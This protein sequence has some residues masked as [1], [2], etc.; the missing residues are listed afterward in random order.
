MVSF[1]VI[2]YHSIEEIK[3]FISSLHQAVS[4]LDCEIIISSNSLYSKEKQTGLISEFPEAVWTFNERN[5]GFAYGMNEGLKVAKGD[6][7]T[8]VNP[9][10]KIQSSLIPMINYLESNPKVGMIAPKI[11]DEDGIIQ[12][13]FRHFVTPWGFFVRQAG[14][15]KDKGKL[16]EKNYQEPVSVDWVIGAFMMCRR[17]FY[18]KAGGLS[19]DY[20]MY[21]EDMD[22]C[23]RV[24]RLGY[25]VVYF[26]GTVIEYKGTRSARKSWKYAKIHIHS[27]L[28]YWRK[29][30]IFGK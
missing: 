30:G 26:P 22:W 3:G 25:E 6:I 12:D 11:V 20:F 21:C 17:D 15:I 1:I 18:D 4:G 14:R 24:H 5:G 28:T 13:S 29:Y 8:V 27:L 9:D 16:H 10:V 23:K 2:E 7:L 19:D